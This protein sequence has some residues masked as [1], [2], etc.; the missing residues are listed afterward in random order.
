MFIVI[1]IIM[2]I[3]IVIIII[4][5]T[6]IAL[7]AE[8]KAGENVAA[9]IKERE[10]LLLPTYRQV[11]AKQ[12]NATDKQNTTTCHSNNIYTSTNQPTKTHI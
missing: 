7:D 11:S 9:A 10:K 1:I 3:I 2:I 6:L 12:T 8:A 5:T 4:I